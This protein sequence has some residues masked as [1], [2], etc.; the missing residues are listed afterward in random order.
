MTRHPTGDAGSRVRERIDRAE[1]LVD[2]A[3]RDWTP[4]QQLVRDIDYDRPV[5]AFFANGP[6]E[7]AEAVLRALRIAA[8]QGRTGVENCISA[9][10]PD[11][12][13]DGRRV[14]VTTLE[15]LVATGE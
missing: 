14:F 9:E 13:T 1:S 2:G 15:W 8:N 12:Q 10:P 7:L 3:T 4:F 5:S 6:G 11:P